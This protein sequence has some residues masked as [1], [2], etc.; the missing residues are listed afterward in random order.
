M[1][2]HTITAKLAADIAVKDV[3]LTTAQAARYLSLSPSSL[4]KMRVYGTG[5]TA[6]YFGRA[7]RYR[8]DDLDEFRDSRRAIST[9]DAADR[10]PRRLADEHLI[11]ASRRREVDAEVEE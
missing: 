7:V 1:T 4:N 9:T 5:P 11:S 10:L 6:V 3:L 2:E 8:R